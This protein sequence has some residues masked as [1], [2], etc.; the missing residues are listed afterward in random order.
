M[1]WVSLHPSLRHPASSSIERPC[2]NRGAI[3]TPD[4]VGPEHRAKPAD[5]SPWSHAT[6]HEPSGACGP[7]A[8]GTGRPSSE[9]T[10]DFSS[11]NRAERVAR[12][13]RR[14]S[15]RPA[16]SRL[17]IVPSRARPLRNFSGSILP[18]I[19]PVAR[20][21]PAA[22]H[23]VMAASGPRSSGQRRQGGTFL[24]PGS[25]SLS[26]AAP[27]AGTPLRGRGT[28]GSP[29]KGILPTAPS[30]RPAPP[31]WAREQLRSLRCAPPCA[32]VLIVGIPP[33]RPIFGSA[34]VGVRVARPA[35]MRP[36]WGASEQ[37]KL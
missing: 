9:V 25:F 23:E 22:L 1:S 26:L 11:A 31:P 24:F 27:P 18:R 5:P 4:S 33:G 13:R 29:L 12:P 7:K 10:A 35:T 21:T 8:A 15:S 32:T 34:R 6:P 16:V 2:R 19:D 3:P 28:F 37:G 17:G 14:E 36:R 20:S 30:S